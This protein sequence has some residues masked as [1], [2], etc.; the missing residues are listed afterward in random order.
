MTNTKKRILFLSLGPIAALILF[1]FFSCSDDQDV[2]NSAKSDAKEITAFAFRAADNDD[3]DADVRATIDKEKKS[4]TASVPFGTDVTKLKPTLTIS[5]KA[6]VSPKDKVEVDFSDDVEYTVTAE[7]GSTQK[8]TVTVT[9]S[10][11]ERDALI[12]IYRSNPNNALGW[13]LEEEDLSKWEGITLGDDNEVVELVLFSKGIRVLPKEIQGLTNLELLVISSDVL[14]EIPLEIGNL[15]KLKELNFSQNQLSEL[16]EEIGRISETLETLS[17]T[18]NKFTTIPSG[19]F[20]LE[21]LQNLLLTSNE[22][23][24]IPKEIINLTNLEFLDIGD[25]KI[26]SLP[27][28][29]ADLTKLDTFLA[30]KNRLTDIPNWFVYLSS[31]TSVSFTQNKLETFPS[32]IFSLDALELLYL[33]DCGL[34]NLPNDIKDL[35]NLVDLS[36]GDNFLVSLPV[37]LGT[38]NKLEFLNVNSNQLTSLPDELAN[39]ESLKTLWIAGN[40]LPDLIPATI[41]QLIEKN[42]VDLKKDPFMFCDVSQ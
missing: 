25:N 9:I 21:N 10:L 30:Y 17:I 16:P 38:L 7:D 2:D 28:Q 37:E 14:S 11:S 8:Y 22:I 27:D 40:Q 12:A 23:E 36:I 35:P 13:N 4:I 32:V 26:S 42:E 1:T 33:D 29:I 39:L 15:P 19:V 6:T 41:C 3:L 18:G 20:E 34:T 31:L 24:S 5:E